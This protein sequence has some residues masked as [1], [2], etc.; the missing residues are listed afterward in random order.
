MR[1][2][3]GEQIRRARWDKKL[4]LNAVAKPIGVTQVHLS[5]VE[6]GRDI[7]TDD[8]YYL[9]VKHLGIVVQKTERECIGYGGTFEAA[10]ASAISERR[11]GGFDDYASDCRL[12]VDKHYIEPCRSDSEMFGTKYAHRHV[13]ILKRLR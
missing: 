13:V 3:T 8:Q 6:H 4:T 10:I 9:V 12:V 7:L 5:N 2:P 11:V 1:R